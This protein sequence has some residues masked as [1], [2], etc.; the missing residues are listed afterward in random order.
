MSGRIGDDAFEYYVSLGP[1]RSYSAVAAHYGVTKRA[2]TKC[3]AREDW[4]DR[5]ARIE[6]EARERSD[7]RL[8]DTLDDMRGRHLT[9]LRA[10]HAR[11]LTALKQFPLN[12]G[13]EAMKASEMVIKLERLVAG[14]ASD[15]T[16]VS[17]EEVTKRELDRWLVQPGAVVE[18]GEE[19]DDVDE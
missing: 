17:V 2:I 14:E 15:R 11:A 8:V 5:L 4:V 3:A 12:S 13:M 19:D 10:M 6:K 9:T 7:K 1:A 16:A 18:R